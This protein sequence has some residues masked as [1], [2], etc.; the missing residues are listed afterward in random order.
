[1]EMVDWALLKSRPEW[2]LLNGEGGGGGGGQGEEDKSLG[3][4]TMS[5]ESEVE[6]CW[7]WCSSGKKTRRKP[8]P[9]FRSLVLPLLVANMPILYLFSLC[10]NLRLWNGREREREP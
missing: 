2:V 5:D 3:L 4:S 9:E 7:C 1:M 8:M 6:R 10:F